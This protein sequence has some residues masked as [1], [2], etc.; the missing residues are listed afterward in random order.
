MRCSNWCALP[1]QSLAEARQDI[2][3]MFLTPWKQTAWGEQV[4]ETILY[5][6]WDLGLKVGHSS[7][8]GQAKLRTG[9]SEAIH[10]PGLPRYARSDEGPVQ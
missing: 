10:V 9:C 5:I 3:I 6:L 4:I 7:S 2:D 1:Q 8:S